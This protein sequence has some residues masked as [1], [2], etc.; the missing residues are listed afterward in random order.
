MS[1]ARRWRLGSLLLRTSGHRL[2]DL[3]LRD[4]YVL[5]DADRTASTRQD[6]YVYVQRGPDR[7][8]SSTP[9]A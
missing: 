7:E 2:A 8:Q 9:T 6:A 4:I 1:R 3:G 5:L